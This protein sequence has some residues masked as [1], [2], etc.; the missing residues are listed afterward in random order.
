MDGTVPG[1]CL[2]TG[3]GLLGPALGAG[4]GSHSIPGGM[5]CPLA[6]WGPAEGALQCRE[7]LQGQDLSWRRDVGL[8]EA[9]PC[10]PHAAAGPAREMRGKNPPVASS[11][12]STSFSSSSGAG[13]DRTSHSSASLRPRARLKIKT[14]H[15][16]AEMPCP[17]AHREPGVH[18]RALRCQRRCPGARR[19]QQEME[20]G[21]A[22][23]DLRQLSLL[24]SLPLP[25]FPSGAAGGSHSSSLIPIRCPIRP[26]ECPATHGREKRAP[27]CS[28]EAPKFPQQ[29]RVLAPL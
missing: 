8:C 15:G 28:V 22:G 7:E 9:D 4:R 19:C 24:P 23:P 18:S 3:H 20:R 2:G 11:S 16:T 14:H 27:R 21:S 29:Q 17:A 1:M 5:S 13:P 25:P 26:R 6:G 12:S 10:A